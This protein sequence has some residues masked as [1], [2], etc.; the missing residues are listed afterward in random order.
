MISRIGVIGLMLSA[1]LLGG[2]FNTSDDKSSESSSEKASIQL[3]P[4]RADSDGSDN[5]DGNNG[6]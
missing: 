2:C 3:Q 4:D 6:K 5:Q 1:M